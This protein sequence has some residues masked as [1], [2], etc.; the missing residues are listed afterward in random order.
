[1]LH[2]KSYDDKLVLYLNLHRP[3]MYKAVR[4]NNEETTAAKKIL[5]GVKIFSYDMKR[6][7]EQSQLPGDDRSDI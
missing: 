4:L 6:K 5:D 7:W 1:M 2:K 3:I